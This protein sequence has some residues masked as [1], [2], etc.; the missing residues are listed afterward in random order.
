M[1]INK[2]SLTFLRKIGGMTIFQE[3]KIPMLGVN[4]SLERFMSL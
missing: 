3:T 2:I 4:M 1:F